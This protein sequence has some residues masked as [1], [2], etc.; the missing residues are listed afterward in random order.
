MNAVPPG[1]PSPGAGPP[2]MIPPGQQ[3]SPADAR[4]AA[5]EVR[6]PV[7]SEFVG[8]TGRPGMRMGG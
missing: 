7:E 3:P 1:G 4:A 8:P 5:E 2:G 6:R